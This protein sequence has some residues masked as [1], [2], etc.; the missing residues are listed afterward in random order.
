MNLIMSGVEE[1]IM[2]V[3]PVEG[4]PEAQGTVSVSD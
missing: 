1:T 4:A 2:V 3:E